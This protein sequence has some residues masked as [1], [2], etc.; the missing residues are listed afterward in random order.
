MTIY[1][2]DFDGNGRIDPVVCYYIGGVSYPANSLDDIA[3]QLPF[4]KKKFLEYKIYAEAKLTDLFTPEQL[5]D[6]A[7]LKAETMHSVMLINQDGQSFIEGKLPLQAQYSPVHN[8]IFTDLNSD[9]KKDLLMTGNNTWTRIKY[10]RYSAN[11]GLMFSG[12]GKGNFSYVPQNISGLNIRGNV[13]GLGLITRNK[14]SVIVAGIN[15]GSAI[16]I[17]KSK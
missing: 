10:G 1:Y 6:A 9:G 17:S 4:L 14:D 12:D 3:E 13:R 5:K 16:L 7:V 2:K 8:F 11:H 15:N